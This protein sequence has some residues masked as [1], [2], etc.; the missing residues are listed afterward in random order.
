MLPPFVLVEGSYAVVPNETESHS[1][2]SGSGQIIFEISCSSQ[3]EIKFEAEVMAP[4][5]RD[6]SFYVQ[7][8]DASLFVWHIDETEET[9]TWREIQQNMNREEWSF[10]VGVGNHTLIF[11]KR[12]DGTAIRSVRIL[13]G[14][15]ECAF[16]T[17]GTCSTKIL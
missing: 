10:Q 17:C 3:T 11:H 12:E 13:N 1:G 14:N 5:T 2:E 4:T 8:D 15:P 9:F 6:N 7:F 16:K